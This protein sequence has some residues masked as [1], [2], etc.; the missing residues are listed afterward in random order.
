MFSKL[1]WSRLQAAA[2]V[3]V[4]CAVLV[5]ALYPFNPHPPN[6]VTWLTV[7]AGL[8]FGGHGTVVSSSVFP[9][10][11]AD[12]SCSIELW[13]DAAPGTTSGTLFSFFS[14]TDPAR[15]FVMQYRKEIVFQR[16]LRTALGERQ[17]SFMAVPAFHPGEPSFVALTENPHARAAYV[18][19]I[20]LEKS[21][22]LAPFCADLTGWL[23]LGTSP[24]S[25]SSWRGTLR[26]L[27]VFGSELS[28]AEA[29]EDF[30]SWK[31]NGR[32]AGA[33]TQNLRA[34]YLFDE[35][36]GAVIHNRAG[37]APDLSIP[38]YYR[39]PFK[40]FLKTPWREF[41]PSLDYLADVLVN[42]VGFV[43]LG[44]VFCSY[45][46]TVRRLGRA[47]AITIF[48]G[49]LVSLSI[50]TLQGFLPTRD[51]GMT[52]IITNTAGTALGTMLF[53]WKPVQDIYSR[54]RI[55]D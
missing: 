25:D 31:D 24:V 44:F 14:P 12:A 19:G 36:A 6:H 42:I 53:H 52:D 2:C 41:K 46:F 32:P 20:R 48:L 22:R 5:A 15:F 4:F 11:A 29:L 49:F 1:D 30:H 51:S 8:H 13:A 40:P 33:T 18:D 27:A 28:A 37:N 38:D 35:R 3:C 39:V 34:L 26:G 55:S 17:W 10:P 47:Q 7:S 16:S 54:W 21:T 43:P 23:V 50:E 45:F 9:A